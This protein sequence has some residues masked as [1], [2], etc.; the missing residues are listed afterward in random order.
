MEPKNKTRGVGR[1][2]A[3]P[4]VVK[5]DMSMRLDPEIAALL[6][7]NGIVKTIEA[8]IPFYLDAVKKGLVTP[9]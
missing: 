4:G 2:S 5:V 6:R 1:P 9:E 3:R 7:E 8:A